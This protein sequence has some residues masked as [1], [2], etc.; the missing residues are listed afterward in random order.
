MAVS[1]L[2][3]EVSDLC[4]GK[5]ALRALSISATIADALSVLKNSDE[6]FISVWD[7]Q[8]KVASIGFEGNNDVCECQCVGKVCMVD[9]ICYLC[10]DKNLLS[11]ADALKAS[12]SVL[13]PK[14]PGLVMRVE[15][16]CRYSTDEN[17]SSQ[18][19]CYVGFSWIFSLIFVLRV[20]MFLKICISGL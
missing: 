12:V 14:I 2:A 9:V 20:S 5:P 7:C 1:L 11:P 6:N 18:C 13:L 15:P 16:S 4:L 10:K 3:H 19:C 8:H 17:H